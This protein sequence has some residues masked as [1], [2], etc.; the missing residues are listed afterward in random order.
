MLFGNIP[1]KHCLGC[2]L[3]IYLLST[4]SDDIKKYTYYAL[5]RMTF[6]NI[7]IKHCLGCYLEIYL[8]STVSGDI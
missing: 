1:I 4:V 8:L 7:P 2:I 3:E 5:S 6:R